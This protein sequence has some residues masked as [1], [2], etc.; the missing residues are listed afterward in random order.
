MIARR[1]VRTV[2]AAAGLRSCARARV[3]YRSRVRVADENLF[4]YLTRLQPDSDSSASLHDPRR[5]H[6]AQKKRRETRPSP[7]ELSAA[8]GVSRWWGLAA[9]RR[10]SKAAARASAHTEFSC[11]L[12]VGFRVYL[13]LPASS[14]ATRRAC[15]GTGREMNP[16]RRRCYWMAR[17]PSQTLRQL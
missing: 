1:K 3:R 5:A 6:D 14:I 13:L 17:A 16:S 15:P 8:P 9:R 11:A 12:V 4:L 10:S 2:M 7:G